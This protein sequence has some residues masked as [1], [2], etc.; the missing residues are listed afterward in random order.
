MQGEDQNNN[1]IQIYL[2]V[3]RETQ[4]PF[5]LFIREFFTWDLR[6][7]TKVYKGLI[8][9]HQQK[10]AS[11]EKFIKG[12]TL[13]KEE[14]HYLRFWCS[15]LSFSVSRAFSFSKSVLS[16]FPRWSCLSPEQCLQKALQLF[17]ATGKE[18]NTARTCL[19]LFIL[20][21]EYLSPC[22]R[23]KVKSFSIKSAS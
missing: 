18:T 11:M 2:S 12:E 8:T 4:H 10:Q 17:Q 22:R 16:S 7:S 6:S 20:G 23:R 21:Y 19:I 13:Y 15:L 5:N 3:Q 1:D 9:S 14:R